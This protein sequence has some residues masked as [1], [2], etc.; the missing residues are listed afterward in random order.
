MIEYYILR[1]I[2]SKKSWKYLLFFL[3][4]CQL[5]YSQSYIVNSYQKINEANGSFIGVLDD[6]DFFGISIDQIGDL[7][8]NGINDIAVGAYADDDGGFNKGAVWI[9]FMDVND[10]VIAHTKISNTSGGFNGVLDEDDRFGG[11]VAYLGDMNNDGLTELAVGADYDGDGGFWHG[12]VWIL[13]LNSDGTV[14]S[15]SKIS[16]T[17]GGFTGFINGDAIFGTDIENIGDLNGD[18]IEDLAVGSRRDGDGGPRRG[19]VWILFMNSDFTVNNYQQISD[20]QGNF[21]AILEFEDYFGGSVANIGDLNGDGVT[22][23]AVGAYRDDDLNINSGCFYVLFMNS[24]GTVNAYQKISN[25]SAGFSDQISSD[26]LFAE[27]IDGVL[28]IDNDGKIEIVVGAMRQI[29]PTL[30]VPTGGFYILELNSDGTLSEEYFYSYAENCFDGLLASGDLFGGSVSILNHDSNNL[31]IVAGAYSDS[32]TGFRNGAAWILNFGEISFNLEMVNQPSGC[33]I[34]DGSFTISGL[35]DNTTYDITYNDGDEQSLTLTSDQNGFLTVSALTPGMYTN[36]VIT[37]SLTG[38]SATITDIELFSES[39]GA[40]FEFTS[41]SD[42]NANDGSIIFSDLNINSNYTITYTVNDN[43]EILNLTS[44]NN[45]EILITSL[46]PGV[47]S[48]ITITEDVT[49][50]SQGFG[51]IEI[52]QGALNAAISSTNSSGCGI[53]DGTITISNLNSDSEY[54]VDFEFNSNPQSVTLVS[55]TNGVIII[56]NLGEG[57]YTS[58]FIAETNS[59][60]NDQFNDIQITSNSFSPTLTIEEF[61]SCGDNNGVVSI[62]GLNNYSNYIIEFQ[63][64]NELQSIEILSNEFGVIELSNLSIGEYSSIFVSEINSS[65]TETLGDFE[66][67][68]VIFDPIISFDN[69]SSCESEDGII[70]ISNLIAGNSYTIS[71]NNG[72]FQQFS[73]LANNSGLMNI[74]NLSVGIYVDIVVT[75]ELNECQVEFSNIE[76]EC[77]ESFECFRTKN[78]FTPNGDGINDYWY[79]EL[80]SNDCSYT[81]TIFDRYGKLIKILTPDKFRW[82]GT[83]NGADMPSTDYWYVVD[84]VNSQ[85][86]QLKYTSHFSLKR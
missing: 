85:G 33:G 64:N 75:D 41:S 32:E 65:C 9:L 1:N 59:N 10:Q 67:T 24:D 11:A 84:Y 4:A 63:L 49:Q 7:D 30:L 47:Y 19:T 82:D 20:T 86:Q 52:I 42:C 12:A 43:D 46:L 34:D 78:F 37:Q 27:S 14:N 80:F 62:Y 54:I 13:S 22:D 29:N 72:T 79:L 50:C 39:L 55:N 53:N 16:D 70:T 76:L 5:L 51:E 56:S 8:G 21:T 81:V 74:P 69:P 17:Q 40:S 68:T 6:Q 66:L 77:F 18:G 83:Y 45:G 3:S 23:L 25:L 44:D 61:P 60:C 31:K 58:I 48:N 35:T 36:I 15:H 28:D 71:F 73:L 38:C 57:N 2:F 26:A